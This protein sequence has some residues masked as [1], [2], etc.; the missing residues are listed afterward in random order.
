MAW[1]YNSSN[2]TL[3][4]D[5]T[6]VTTE[7]WSGH[8]A[9]RNNPAM[10]QDPGIG[11]IPRGYWQIGGAVDS[12]KLGPIAMPLSPCANPNDEFWIEAAQDLGVSIPPTNTFGRFGFW[13]HGAEFLNP[14]ESSH[15]CIILPRAVRLEVSISI[16]K[17]LEVV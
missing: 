9:G 12:Q 10:E 6:V 13:M 17:V 2:G 5:G 14:E 7:S 1:M 8:D 15:G 16:D 3:S 4:H 11:P